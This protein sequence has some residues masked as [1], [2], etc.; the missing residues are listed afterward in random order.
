VIG[1]GAGALATYARAGDHF[2]FYE[3]N[4]LV[5]EIAQRGFTF[6]RDSAGRIE[7]ALGDGRLSLEREDPQAFDVLVVD[8]FTGDSIPVH[9]ITRESFA[10]YFRHLR[11]GGLLAIHITNRH[12]NLAPV[13][14]ASAKAV[15]RNFVGIYSRGAPEQGTHSAQWMLV[16]DDSALIPF[17]PHAAPP[18]ARS[19]RAWTDDYSDLFAA[20]L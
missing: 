2:R 19:L 11:Q 8:A 10:L 7:I 4:P 3:I 6:L 20:L 15:G 14:A 9:L 18:P 12:V 17:R 16:G 5:I 1:L 13:I